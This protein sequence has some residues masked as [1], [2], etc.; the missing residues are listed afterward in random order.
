MNIT[1]LSVALTLFSLLSLLLP[2]LSVIP[3][4]LLREQITAPSKTVH[5][6]LNGY[7]A[8]LI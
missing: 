5:I 1:F 3:R 8:G 7:Y 2:Q 4:S 6:Q